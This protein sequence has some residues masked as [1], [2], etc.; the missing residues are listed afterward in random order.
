MHEM[1]LKLSQSSH[2][3]V[4]RHRPIAVF[5]LV[6]QVVQAL[7]ISE[8]NFESIIARA[9]PPN[10]CNDLHNC[11]TIWNIIWSCLATIFACTWLALHLNIPAINE[12]W[13]MITLRKAGIM[14]LAVIAPEIVVV[15][16]MR[17]WLVARR[18]AISA[19]G[20]LF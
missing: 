19:S 11:R 17:Q 5:Y 10:N 2:V 1:G 13:F 9:A 12:G 7:P 3:Q 18:I 20:C 15:W 16:A 4:I 14:I 8:S 6:S